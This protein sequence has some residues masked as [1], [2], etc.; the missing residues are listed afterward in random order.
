MSSYEPAFLPWIMKWP[1]EQFFLEY[2]V[3]C[4]RKA[5][6]AHNTAM[7]IVLWKV[8]AERAKKKNMKRRKLMGGITIFMCDSFT[9]LVRKIVIVASCRW[10]GGVLSADL[11]P[12]GCVSNSSA[13]PGCGVDHKKE[14]SLWL[15]KWGGQGQM[16]LQGKN[17]KMCIIYSH[18]LNV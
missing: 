17:N 13:E 18:L 10:T 5:S 15:R 4:V 7:K 3:A 9:F 12:G 11:I 8:E 1:I 14:L 6:V 2:R 16:L